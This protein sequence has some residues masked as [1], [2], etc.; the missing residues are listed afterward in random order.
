MI[1]IDRKLAQGKF[2][3]YFYIYGKIR[4][5]CQFILSFSVYINIKATLFKY[6]DLR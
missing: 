4:K 5:K 1:N 6:N 3:V 2:G